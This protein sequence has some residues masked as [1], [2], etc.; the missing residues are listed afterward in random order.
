MAKKESTFLNM[1]LT[2]L[3]VTS[4]AALA[5]GWVQIATQK[6]IEQNQKEKL[7]KALQ[8]VLPEFDND[9]ITEDK[10][11]IAAPGGEKDSITVY[12]AE[13]GG[14]KVGYALKTF[15]R[16]GYGGRISLIVGFKPNGSIINISVLKHEE[17]PGMGD[18]IEKSKS[19]WSKQFTGKNPQDYELKVKKDGGNVDAITA[20]TISSR[21]YCDAVKR[22]YKVFRKEI[23]GGE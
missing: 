11:T 1:F 13:K 8:N 2:L 16:K 6:A 4:V 19:D 22:A 15:T 20:A 12:P 21:A 3:I 10:Y 5:L 23:K 14:E 17:T 18:K 9:D 7:E